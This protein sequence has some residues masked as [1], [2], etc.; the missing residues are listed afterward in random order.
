MR[1]WLS[2]YLKGVSMGAA[3]AVPGVSGGTIALITGIYERLVGAIAAFDPR[4]LA[5]LPRVYDPEARRRVAGMLREMDVAFL[6]VLGAG[7]MTAIVGVTGAVSR[8]ADSSPAVLFAFFFGLIAASAL[9]LWSEVRLDTGGEKAAA[10]VGFVVAFLLAS[11]ST[12]A[13][14]PHSPPVLFVVGAIAICAM[15]LPGVS[16]SFL[17]ILFGQYIFM[18]DTL[19]AFIDEAV[20]VVRG[21]PVESAVGPAVAVVSFVAGAAVGILTFARVVEWALSNHREVTLTFLVALMVGALRLPVAKIL[22]AGGEWPVARVAAVL[23]AG[24]AGTAAVLLVDYYTDDL[25]YV[26]DDPT[27]TPAPRN[28]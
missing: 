27:A 24:V 10:V 13:A 22:G 28:D 4:V 15:I 26:E 9:V 14:I 11:E 1:E 19:H 25:D 18:S 3:D 6:L 17:L 23:L 21:G 7:I 12:A 8:I 5:D 2:I 20:G 16:G